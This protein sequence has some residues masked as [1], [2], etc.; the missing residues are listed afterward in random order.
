[1]QIPLEDNFEDIIGKA[2]RGLGLSDEDLAFRAGI[3]VGA[4]RQMKGGTVLE[5][6]ARLIA[7]LLG[8]DADSLLAIGRR[9]WPP[10]APST[11]AR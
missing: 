4:L 7:P 2:A 1:M 5:G 3:S 8:L 9:G 10:G 11:Q 6:P